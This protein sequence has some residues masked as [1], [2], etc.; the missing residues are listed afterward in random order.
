VSDRILK[1]KAA[2]E[3][4]PPLRDIIAASGLSAQKALGQ[5]FL[6]DLNLT[7]KIVRSAQDRFKG[8]WADVHAIEIGPGPGGL[9][10]S[11]LKS[12]ARKVTAIE[13]D[14]RAVDAL[15]SLK[16]ASDGDLEIIQADALEV[17]LTSIDVTPRIIVAN[18]PYNIATP[19]L[20]N[21]LRQIR[22]DAK[23]FSQ[24][25]LMFQKE[26]AERIAARVDTKAYGRLGIIAQ[27]V[28]RTEKLFDLPPSAFTP[29]P[30][31]TSAVVQFIPRDLPKDAPAFDAV[32]RVTAAA[33]Q[34]RRKMIRSS[35]KEYLPAIE[36]LGI[37][38]QRRA[39]TLDVQDFLNIAK[40]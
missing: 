23:S 19:L 35:L 15:S 34:Q 22:G 25:T 12:G 20:I 21:W 14:S 39:E 32:E 17:D 2:V 31:V 10:R 33:F 29:P 38:P 11:L 3:A 4:L 27:W 24:M 18:L 6:L 1:R 9:T 13:F 5:N 8:N 28:C 36:A 16:L 37:D 30:K 40:F 26:V 7:D